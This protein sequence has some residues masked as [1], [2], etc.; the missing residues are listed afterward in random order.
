MT[1][2]EITAFIDNCNSINK[3]LIQYNKAK[4]A[5][6][7]ATVLS[8]ISYY[9]GDWI[10]ENKNWLYSSMDKA[11]NLYQKATKEGLE[12]KGKSLLHVEIPYLNPEDAPTPSNIKF[13]TPD[14]EPETPVVPSDVL[15]SS[16]YIPETGTVVHTP[17]GHPPVAE[18]KTVHIPIEVDIAEQTQSSNQEFKQ[19][20]SDVL[21]PPIHTEAKTVYQ[22][23]VRNALEHAPIEYGIEP[24]HHV[25]IIPPVPRPV[26]AHAGLIFQPAP[27]PVLPPLPEEIIAEEK[28]ILPITLTA[29]PEGFV[30]QDKAT[31]VYP[32]EAYT[33]WRGDR[34]KQKPYS[35]GRKVNLSEYYWYGANHRPQTTINAKD[36]IFAK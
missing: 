18:T 11:E 21:P 9:E 27:A 12:S 22:K 19:A 26:P 4:S 8:N 2:N 3:N 25:E 1:S 24:P 23:E 15:T 36:F 14:I 28:T 31:G 10:K 16:T 13:H 17:A 29:S 30:S 20:M 34:F 6:K 33:P 7:T 5:R 35:V 32:P